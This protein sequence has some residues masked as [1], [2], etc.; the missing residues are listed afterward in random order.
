[1]FRNSFRDNQNQFC[2][3]YNYFSK[4]VPFKRKCGKICTARQ[5]TRDYAMLLKKDTL[6]LPDN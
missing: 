1:M 4:F 3:E 6:C 2:V 5:S